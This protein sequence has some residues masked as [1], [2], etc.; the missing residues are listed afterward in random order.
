MTTVMTARRARDLVLQKYFRT[1]E[2]IFLI[3]SSSLFSHVTVH[4][5]VP[6]CCGIRHSNSTSQSLEL[7]GLV[8]DG[9]F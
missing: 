9:Y 8:E 5:T 4:P 1:F 2:S 3:K 7:G 6:G